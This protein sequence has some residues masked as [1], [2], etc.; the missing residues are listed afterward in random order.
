[1]MGVE[2]REE[3]EV[4]R[5]SMR[6]TRE[7]VVMPLAEAAGG[8]SHTAG[9]V[10]ARAEAF[11]ARVDFASP[12]CARDILDV[13][14]RFAVDAAFFDAGAT[15]VELPTGIEAFIAPRWKATCLQGARAEVQGE[16]ALALAQGPLPPG[17]CVVRGSED[18]GP[19]G[20]KHRRVVRGRGGRRGFGGDEA[21]AEEVW[22]VE[23]DVAHADLLLRRRVGVGERRREEEGERAESRE[24]R[25][26]GAGAEHGEMY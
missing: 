20:L 13:W 10:E 19:C 25:G 4:R 6:G 5:G 1:M 22:E 8:C 12:N 14:D 18:L 2:K 21:R 16:L 3:V 9:S 23:D 17:K 24:A 11:C 26:R 15:R 7:L